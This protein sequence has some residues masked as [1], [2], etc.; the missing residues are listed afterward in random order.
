MGL[1]KNKVCAYIALDFS[2]RLSFC[3]KRDSGHREELD[4]L[5]GTT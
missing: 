5:P 4:D 2:K 1:D 3:T